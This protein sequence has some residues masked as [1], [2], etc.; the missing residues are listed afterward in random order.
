MVKTDQVVGGGLSASK[1]FTLAMS[2]V[3]VDFRDTL[4]LASIQAEER[5]A[6]NTL[7]FYT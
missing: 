7:L 4:S 1:A 2:R 3:S 5:P 6:S